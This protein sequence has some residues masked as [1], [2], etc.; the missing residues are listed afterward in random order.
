MQ[1]F[2]QMSRLTGIK[3]LFTRTFPPL[4]FE[5]NVKVRCAEQAYKIMDKSKINKETKN[6]ETARDKGVTS[7]DWLGI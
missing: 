5:N 6:T 1:L 7:S 3:K 4:F 2:H